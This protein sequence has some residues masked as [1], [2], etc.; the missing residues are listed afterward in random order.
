MKGAR[1]QEFKDLWIQDGWM[2]DPLWAYHLEEGFTFR[3][4]RTRT[5]IVH[6]C[7]VNV[8][9]IELSLTL[10]SFPIGKI[11]YMF[12]LGVEN[13][14]VWIFLYLISFQ[15]V[16]LL[17]SPP[18]LQPQETYPQFSSSKRIHRYKIFSN[19]WEISNSIRIHLKF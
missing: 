12:T 10:K 1:S 14:R 4:A 13:T 16:L 11:S 9:I 2:H 15:P 17:L 7:L 5:F 8:I 18:L 3:C 6:S 19:K